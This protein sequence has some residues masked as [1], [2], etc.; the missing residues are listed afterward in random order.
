MD[1][2]GSPSEGN[3]G[4]NP[5]QRLDNAFQTDGNRPHN[6]GGS[7][8]RGCSCE[9]DMAR[10]GQFCVLDPAIIG[11]V[12]QKEVVFRPG[13]APVQNTNKL[14]VQMPD[15]DGIKTGFSIVAQTYGAWAQGAF[16]NL[17]T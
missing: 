15:C 7:R 13:D 6:R 1:P 2:G 8:D 14:L 12:S 9:F 4:R 5:I 16:G 10:L 3:S 17:G 11:W